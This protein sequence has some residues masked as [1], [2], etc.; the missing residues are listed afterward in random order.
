[1]KAVKTKHQAK[2]TEKFKYLVGPR[3]LKD[4]GGGGKEETW[5][6]RAGEEESMRYTSLLSLGDYSQKENCKK[7][8]AFKPLLIQAPGTYDKITFL[9][10]GVHQK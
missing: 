3:V 6:G 1:V 9:N 10:T 2:F 8:F 5:G 7:I 4:L